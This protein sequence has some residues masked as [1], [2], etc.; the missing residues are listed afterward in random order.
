MKRQVL[1]IVLDGGLNQTI[2]QTLLPPGAL[3]NASNYEESISTGYRRIDG[4]ER[5]DGR[6]GSPSGATYTR[7]DFTTGGPRAIVA[8]DVVTGL[9]SGATAYVLGSV[10]ISGAW[11][12]ANA[13]GNIGVHRITGTFLSNENLIVS[14]VVAATISLITVG[15][16][17]DDAGRKTY[18]RGAQSY[19]R[20]L[21]GPVPGAG[22]IQGVQVYNN[23]VYA[24]RNNVGNT[25]SIM[26]VAGSSGWTAVT[27]PVEVNFT[28]A[29]GTLP[30]PGA[31]IVQGANSGLLKAIFVTSGQL[32]L[33]TAAGRMV[34]SNMTGT[35]AAGAFTSGITATSGVSTVF[36]FAPGG[37]FDFVNYNFYGAA[38]SQRMYGVNGKNRGFEFDGTSLI[39][40]S[41]GM[42]IDTPTHLASHKNRLFFSFPKGSLQFSAP[43][44]PTIWSALIGAGEIGIGDEIT[45]VYSVRQDVL[46]IWASASVSLLYGNGIADFN[47]RKNS[48]Q[49]GGIPFSIQEMDG[50]VTFVDPRGM[51]SLNAVQQ[52]G[53]F[54][55]NNLADNIQQLF[56]NLAKTLTCSL[57]SRK[58][59]H[60]RL[61][62]GDKSTFNLAFTSNVRNATNDNFGGGG[63][64]QYGATPIWYRQNYMHQFNCSANGDIVGDETVFVGD[65]G[66][67]SNGQPN[68]GYVFK[69]DIG[70]NFDGLPIASLLGTPFYH[71]QSPFVKKWLRRIELETN[72]ALPF[73]L[74]L[75]ADFNYGSENTT[76]IDKLS[77]PNAGG[78]WDQALWEQFFW[79]AP[80][81]GTPSVNMKG[82]GK[83][84]ALTIAHSDDIDAS[85]TLE[86]INV[87]YDLLNL[88]R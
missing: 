18:L 6:A 85:F 71:Y 88:Q 65:D 22:P 80:F 35:F 59:R 38:G 12:S 78:Y 15:G 27:M 60:I 70:N 42:T 33:G 62:L 19:L 79:D 69:L 53:D 9:T 11:A 31:T 81:A 83:N 25:A 14:S 56:V 8:G 54:Q 28:A 49:T 26:Y 10:L 67:D 46:G 2:N 3:I 58:K 48:F 34:L 24:F 84:I 47:L 4:Y 52:Y 77:T 73:L 64:S 32:K 21:I 57:L 17:I 41:T 20:N 40:I 86:A 13:V 39:P 16:S 68:G 5:F 45:A 36:V 37:R 87:T 29:S 72:A 44:T 55:P 23:N 50:V 1:Q 43:G 74:Q 76:Q 61:F 82:T 30:A 7:L 51:F 63:Q 66:N 75:K